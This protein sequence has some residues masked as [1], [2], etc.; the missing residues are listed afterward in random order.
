MAK[1][2]SAA[3]PAQFRKLLAALSSVGFKPGRMV[4]TPDGSITVHA[5]G[6]QAE[7]IDPLA[8]W[9]ASRGAKH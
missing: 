4:V 1:P 6:Q 7:N 9:E 2:P 8:E 3:S 5:E